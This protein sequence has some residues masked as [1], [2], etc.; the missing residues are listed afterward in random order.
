[1]DPA[2]Y[3]LG[4]EDPCGHYHRVF[5]LCVLGSYMHYI[6]SKTTLSQWTLGCL[7]LLNWTDQQ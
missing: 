2:K 1:M 4:F 6:V 3:V 5:I 7:R